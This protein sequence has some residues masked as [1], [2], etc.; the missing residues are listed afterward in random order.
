MSRSKILYQHVAYFYIFASMQNE[1]SFK[2]IPNQVRA[3]QQATEQKINALNR[4]RDV[5]MNAQRNALQNQHSTEMAN[6]KRQQDQLT[7]ERNNQIQQY[8]QMQNN[9]NQQIQQAHAQ[10]QQ[11]QQRPRKYILF[12]CYNVAR[13]L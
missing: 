2:Y 6:I 12:F 9:L 10:I 8:Q 13:Y 4:D 3:M 7:A 5:A 1:L 11:L